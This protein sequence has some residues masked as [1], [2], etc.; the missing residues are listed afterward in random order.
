MAAALQQASG[1]AV[2]GQTSQGQ[3]VV[4][5]QGSQVVTQGQPSHLTQGQHRSPG[6][7]EPSYERHSGCHSS[8]TRRRSKPR[9][10]CALRSALIF[11][12]VSC[13]TCMGGAATLVHVVLQMRM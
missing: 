6:V 3:A 4:A 2:G 5:V 1:N 12:V 7:G 13:S 8:T 10:H 11:A 9:Y